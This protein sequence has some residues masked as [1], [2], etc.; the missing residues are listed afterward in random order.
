M[1]YSRIDIL[2]A[3][4]RGWLVIEPFDERL[5]KPNAIAFRLDSKIAVPKGGLVDL[6]TDFS[7]FFEEK[8]IDENGF[9]LKS[10]QFILA[11]TYEKIALNNRLAMFIEG[12]STLARLGISVT[13]TA[14]TVE[15]GH[16]FLAEK[17]A[18]PR[19]IVLEIKNDGPFDFILKPK[20][21]IAKG[22]IVE[23]KTPSDIYYDAYGKYARE[24]LEDTL[25]PRPD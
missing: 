1:I 6:K 4:K 20:M 21:R 25:W 17:R 22:I 14:M 3:V 7:K 5:L 13:Q 16:G 19:K 18:R 15:A 24:A 2:E 12:R 9:L 23:L 8:R 11:R 10:G